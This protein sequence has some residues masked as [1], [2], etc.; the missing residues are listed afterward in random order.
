MFGLNIASYYKPFD[1]GI[2]DDND[3]FLL[4]GKEVIIARSNY[5][6]VRYLSIME[7]VKKTVY[8]HFLS[9]SNNW[10]ID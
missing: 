3:F 1:S 2:G 9:T 4:R 5:V 8:V 6:G 10:Q 7:H